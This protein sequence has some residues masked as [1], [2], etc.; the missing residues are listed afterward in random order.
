MAIS[1]PNNFPHKRRKE[2]AM[3]DNVQEIIRGALAAGEEAESMK[4]NILAH[5]NID[6]SKVVGLT[7]AHMNGSWEKKIEGLLADG[8]IIFRIQTEFSINGHDT[9]AYFAK[10]KP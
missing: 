5:Q 1:K 2:I 7:I 3:T 9:V 4:V 8:W 6:L 10:L